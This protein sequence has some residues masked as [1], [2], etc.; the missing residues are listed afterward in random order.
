MV[1]SGSIL[2]G[3]I[4]SS[5]AQ[6]GQAQPDGPPVLSETMANPK[7][8]IAHWLSVDEKSNDCVN[9]DDLMAR[10][11]IST[12]RKRRGSGITYSLEDYIR[13]CRGRVQRNIDM[14]EPQARRMCAHRQ[15]SARLET[16]CREWED[17]KANYIARIMA[18]DGP[19]LERYK[20]FIGGAR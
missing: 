2:F 14:V 10:N 7:W 18:S 19:T 4:Q 12:T 11:A 16:I 17:N 20:S 6:G 1:A 13:S 5:D 8:T 15:T 9:A 3:N